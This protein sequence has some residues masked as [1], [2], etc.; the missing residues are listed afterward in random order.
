MFLSETS[1]A[2]MKDPS[3]KRSITLEALAAFPAQLEA[4]C[5]A[6]P[7]EYKHWVPPAWDGIAC[8]RLTAFD[9]IGHLR[10][11]EVHGYQLRMSLVLSE[12]NPA[13]ESLDSYTLTRDRSQTS[14]SVEAVLAE[15]R[16]ARS[17]TLALLESLS[18][19]QLQRTASLAGHGVLSLQSLVHHLCS[20]DQQHFFYRKQ[21][22]VEAARLDPE[23]DKGMVAFMRRALVDLVEKSHRTLTKILRP[24]GV[25]EGDLS[26]TRK[27]LCDR[28]D[29]FHAD[30]MK[31]ARYRYV[32]GGYLV[33]MRKEL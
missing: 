30:F 21:G 8:E 9:Q 13:L 4:H 10:D 27:A 32:R 2:A 3:P 28:A 20:H 26:P 24:D 5:A 25:A 19:D 6:I 14:P 33:L 7:D 1:R 23:L 22:Y 31:R 11:I 18:A 29:R 15:F 16:Q 12:S 17:H